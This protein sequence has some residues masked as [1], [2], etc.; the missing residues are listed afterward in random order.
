MSTSLVAPSSVGSGAI[1]P[2]NWLSKMGA[3]FGRQDMGLLDSSMIGEREGYRRLR[4]WNE[5]DQKY[6]DRYL[7]QLSQVLTA[8]FLNQ[9]H[10]SALI[11]LATEMNM[12]LERNWKE[13][14]QEVI[15]TTWAMVAA[16]GVPRSVNW[17]S[18]SR[19]GRTQ[20]FKATFNIANK[21]L[22]DDNFGWQTL[23]AQFRALMETGLH[24]IMLQTAMQLS[25]RPQI[26]DIERVTTRGRPYRYADHYLR[27]T[28]FFALGASEPEAIVNMIVKA[29]ARWADPS[30]PADTIIVGDG[31]EWCLEEKSM[32]PRAYP[33][34]VVDN[35]PDNVVLAAGLTELVS[36]PMTTVNISGQPFLLLK[37]P[38]FRATSETPMA[39]REQPLRRHIILARSYLLPTLRYGSQY[40]LNADTLAVP[41]LQMDD[42]NAQWHLQ[43]MAEGIE[44]TGMYVMKKDVKVPS[45]CAP[46]NA[47]TLYDDNGEN[48][49]AQFNTRD[50]RKLLHL[51][52]EI[53][54]STPDN[55]GN[56]ANAS[57]AQSAGATRDMFAWRELPWYARMRKDVKGKVGVQAALRIGQMHENYL[58]T[59]R[60]VEMVR[61][62]KATAKTN[63]HEKHRLFAS[64]MQQSVEW[65]EKVGALFEELTLEDGDDAR[66]TEQINLIVQRMCG[67]SSAK[68]GPSASAAKKKAASASSVDESEEDVVLSEDDAPAKAGKFGSVLSDEPLAS[69][70]A[71]YKEAKVIAAAYRAYEAANA[72]PLAAGAAAGT[73]L[74]AA[75]VQAFPDAAL[76]HLSAH[77][78]GLQELERK[79]PA[80]AARLL[81]LLT[82]RAT[83]LKND[84]GAL[85]VL[86]KLT[87]EQLSAL[88]LPAAPTDEQFNAL[89]RAVPKQSDL[90]GARKELDP[91]S[92]EYKAA[93]EQTR[94]L[95]ARLQAPSGAAPT[96]AVSLSQL[97]DSAKLAVVVDKIDGTPSKTE[98]QLADDLE[99]A[100]AMSTKN[101]GERFQRAQAII[102]AYTAFKAG[103]KVQ[104]SSKK[105][106]MLATSSTMG[107]STPNMD[108]N[109]DRMSQLAAILPQ[110]PPDELYMTIGLMA[111]PLCVP[112]LARLA[113]L[114]IQIM[115]GRFE[116]WAET[117]VSNSMLLMRR[118]GETCQN[119]LSPLDAYLSSRGVVGVTD[120]T[121]QF[122][123]GV[124]WTNYKG[125]TE[126][127]AFFPRR[128][129]G[130]TGTQL[131]A[132]LEDVHKILNGESNSQ[133]DLVFL[134]H[135]ITETKFE[136]PQNF[137]GDHE[138]IDE[139]AVGTN[140][141]R[142]NRLR[143][144]SGHALFR[145]LIGERDV[146][147]HASILQDPD[148]L[149]GGT[150]STYF[151]SHVERAATYYFSESR[152]DWSAPKAGT[153]CLGELR[154]N[155]EEFCA[156]VLNGGRHQFP[157]DGAKRANV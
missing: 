52:E 18:Q 33:M 5:L 134:T 120:F 77:T 14:H 157:Y 24:T 133:M 121:A 62:L 11:Y 40:E 48:V 126:F 125:I 155:H 108:F 58:P 103:K 36:Q 127:P 45:L 99:A 137:L 29:R 113:R 2:V 122:D 86:A 88:A 74:T 93:F 47:K 110:L 49:I 156:Q 78:A 70:R 55:A 106:S 16:T 59:Q 123:Q 10:G 38:D 65:A 13:V 118:G 23:M 131:A 97:L 147:R 75:F 28:R 51:Y 72:S 53:T 104:K 84:V 76:P 116:R 41:I 31:D 9:F 61:S 32:D 35:T 111:L 92:A 27:M 95:A 90:V 115:G 96:G 54:S 30:R 128:I 57:I 146:N 154:M 7:Y 149:T 117:Y 67:L 17:T 81:G 91:A 89:R 124:R 3:W 68:P 34:K 56:S 129:L 85:A 138:I 71:A 39:E 102:A 109:E 15:Q 142:D 143:K 100:L 80:A 66:I 42:R 101:D 107:G 20:R 152:R 136:W 37:M 119:I 64:M 105:A 73:P 94:A 141:L 6:K 12:T 98:A 83:G 112:V 79:Q 130:G 43:D 140:G 22:G 139:E 114:G 50:Q 82:E 26:N 145:M 63:K 150:L 144:Y 46:L 148:V 4:D 8:A 60:L 151:C 19:V 44:T 1:A 135:P 69:F 132:T 153:G 87:G 21:L 25:M